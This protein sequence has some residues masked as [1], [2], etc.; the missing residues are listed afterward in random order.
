MF[1]M[2][3]D[4]IMQSAI[5]RICPETIVNGRLFV[6]IFLFLSSNGNENECASNQLL[7]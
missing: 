7:T 4:N 6:A 1:Y 3:H 2:I 5:Q